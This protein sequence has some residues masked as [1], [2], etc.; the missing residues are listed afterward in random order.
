MAWLRGWID[1]HPQWSRKRLA[2]ELC[3]RWEWVDGRGRLKDFA[4]RSPANLF[5]PLDMAAQPQPPLVSDWA[6]A[7]LFLAE[8]LK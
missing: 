1:G 3:Q 2:R 8:A 7:R 6:Q 4:A 5:A